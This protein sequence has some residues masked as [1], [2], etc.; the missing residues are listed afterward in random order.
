MIERI[1]QSFIKDMRSYFSEE[2]CGNIIVEKYINDRFID[3]EEPGAMELGSYFEYVL[4]EILL[5]PGQGAIPKNGVKPVPQYMASVVKKNKGSTQGLGFS[6][7]YSEYRVAQKNAL[8]VE[9]CLKEMKLKG[10]KVGVHKDLGRFDGTIDM[11]VECLEGF[12]FTHN[13]EKIAFKKGQLLVIDLKYSGLIGNGYNKSKH[14]WNWTDEQ[15]QYHGTQAKHYY[16]LMKLPFFFWVTQSNN[17]E[18]TKPN[19]GIFYVP[20]DEHMVEQHVA[21]GNALMGKFK[22]QIEFG[23]VPR[24]SYSKCSSCGLR[25]EC[26]DK[27]TYPH[28]EIV[29]LTIGV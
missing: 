26:K 19:M 14:G 13:G 7:M 6:D 25:N 16:M 20:V 12:A 10:I 21:E 23:F 11:I 24:P 29:D 4:G 18:G 8:E 27:H 5:G 28:P 2:E 9:R 1:S 22:N 15:K 3:S 17:K